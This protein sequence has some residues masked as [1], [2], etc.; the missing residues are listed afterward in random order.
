MTLKLIFRLQVAAL[1][2]VIAVT[3]LPVKIGVQLFGVDSES[4]IRIYRILS[5][6]IILVAQA[7]YIF[8][9]KLFKVTNIPVYLMGNVALVSIIAMWL[10]GH[11]GRLI[12]FNFMRDGGVLS[13]LVFALSAPTIQAFVQVLAANSASKQ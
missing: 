4:S 10:A 1:I 8:P 6:S 3:I 11:D 13:A 7:M 9:K 12:S 2:A 5:L